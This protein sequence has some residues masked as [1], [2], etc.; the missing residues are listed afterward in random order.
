MG[1]PWQHTDECGF[2]GEI[3][4]ALTEEVDFITDAGYSQDTMCGSVAEVMAECKAKCDEIGC[5][6][7]FYQE[8]PNDAGCPSSPQG[9]YQICGYTTAATFGTTNHGHRAGSQVCTPRPR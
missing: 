4:T 6:G 8:H 5:T 7:F 3:V 1:T 2:G 9:G